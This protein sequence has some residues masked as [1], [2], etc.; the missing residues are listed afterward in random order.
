MSIFREIAGYTFGHADVVRRAMSKKKASVLL[1]ERESFV[2]GAAERGID[3]QVAEQLF[4]DMES[5]ANYAFNKSH[6]A[7]YAMISY[8]TAYLKCHHP[9]AYFSALLTSVL[10]NQTK[11]AEY[12]SECAQRGIR[13]L[14]P[15]INESRIYFSVSGKDI[16]FGLLALKNVGKQ[17]LE[18]ILDERRHGPFASFEDFI[19]RMPAGEL[20]KRMVEALLK[21][22]TFDRLGVYR[23]RL[24]R[25]YESMIDRVAEK[26]KNN[27]DGQL[28]MF[29]M[30]G[31]AS[32]QAPHCEYPDIPELGIRE[33]LLMEKEATGMYFSGQMLDEYA[34]HVKALSP[35]PISD[36]VGDEQDPADKSR[37]SVAGIVTSVTVKNTRNG[38]RMAFFTLE[39]RMAE[40]ECVAF[41][42][43]FTEYSHLLHR[44]SA[45]FVSGTISVREDEPPKILVNSIVPLVDDAH[46][47]PDNVE[48]PKQTGSVG[49]RSTYTTDESAQT[50]DAPRAPESVSR[51]R[52]Q[53]RQGGV[54]S[55]TAAQSPRRL[56]L[57]VPDAH[58][59]LYLK[60]LNLVEL[61][62][63]TFPVFFYYADEKR[64]EPEARGLAISD[65]VLTR[66]KS[67]LG[68]ENV[69]LK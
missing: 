49:E 50:Q 5:F 29:S 14:P 47:R 25:V 38:D 24:L 66:L 34:C 20:N 59:T 42:R 22:G 56:F 13:V 23:S 58:G 36:F 69:I 6:A 68:E 11:V 53:T 1:A 4:S 60:T 46:Y 55:N 52:E 21:A 43:Q 67:L 8:R 2:T 33:K 57:R 32:D 15:D 9:H 37:A 64:Y 28:D 45:L 17:F 48:A 35:A 63:G 27:L 31:A 40:I 51:Q 39:D 3:A 65:Y 54:L 19:N 30:L 44:D 10:G 26:G 62:E 18:K 41:A 12:I 16:R 7:A 61:F